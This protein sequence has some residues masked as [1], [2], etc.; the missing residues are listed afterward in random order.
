MASLLVK[1]KRMRWHNMFKSYLTIAIR[2]LLCNKLFSLLNIFGLTIGLTI[3][4]VTAAFVIYE[5]GYDNHYKNKDNLY[6]ISRY[7]ADDDVH[8]AAIGIPFKPLLA[9]RITDIEAIAQA[10]MTSPA[11]ISRNDVHIHAENILM[12]D[13]DIF[14]VLELEFLSGNPKAALTRASTMVLTESIA[15]KLF[16]DEDALG[17]NIFQNGFPVEITGVIKDMPKNTHLDFSILMSLETLRIW[18]AQDFDNWDWNNFYTYARLKPGTDIKSLEERISILLRE[19]GD[20]ISND[21]SLHFQ[22][23]KDIHLRSNKQYEMKANGSYL[24]VY[25]FS[26]IAFVILLIACINFM[27]LSTAR[28]GKRAKEVG[29]RKTAGA[30]RP[31]LIV[32]F[33]SESTLLTLIA[34]LLALTIVE[35]NMP[36]FANIVQRPLDMSIFYNGPM[37]VFVLLAA[38]AV[39]CAAGSYPAFYLSGFK[40]AKVLKGEETHGQSAIRLRKILVV[41]QF[42]LSIVLII[43]T[44]VVVKQ[45]HYARSMDPGYD[46]SQNVYVTF[47]HAPGYKSRNAMYNAFRERLLQHSAIQSVTAA[48][49]LPTMALRDMWSYVREDHNIVAENMISLPTLNASYD[50]FEHYQIELIAGRTFSRELGDGYVRV[51]SNEQPIGS[52][53]AVISTSAAKA[54]GY[55]PQEAV[56]KIIKIPFPPGSTNYRIVGVVADIQLGSLREEQQPQVYHL[57]DQ[58]ERFVSIRIDENKQQEALSFIDA[59]WAEMVP[60]RPIMRNFLDENFRAMYEHEEKQAEI[61]AL[62]SLI[63]ILVACLGLFGLSAFTADRRKKEIGVRKVMGASVTSIVM[64]LTREFTLLVLIANA[65]AWPITYLLM[66]RW[67]NGFTQHI[68]LSLDLFLFAG[69]IALAIAWLTI[70]SNAALSATSRPVKCLRYE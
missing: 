4:L 9:E 35:I 13:N 29:I 49:Q 44:L 31:Q 24:I 16:G 50:F 36:L 10:G 51:P 39:G 2:N 18:W 15:K 41:I 70:A 25:S 11:H 14:E 55:S 54:L 68:S 61:F 65:V 64:L 34:M 22:S 6:R 5:K 17:Q 26:A 59:T 38:I 48:Q 63:A 43:S 1:T 12:A 33:L 67:L 56:D 40:P 19:Q 58:Q 8:V 57:V 23:I 66:S 32:Q 37:I 46:K 7:Y 30:S 45:T 69:L 53:I 52:G 47:N 27:N 20:K 21:Q 42:T 28:A 3:G 62:F 60:D